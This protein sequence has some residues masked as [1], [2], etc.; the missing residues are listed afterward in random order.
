[1]T[2]YE[3]LQV[4]SLL[5]CMILGRFQLFFRSLICV[6]KVAS[7][8]QWLKYSFHIIYTITEQKR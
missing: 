2:L 7:M 8:C 3:A 6:V 4:L 1:M 5:I